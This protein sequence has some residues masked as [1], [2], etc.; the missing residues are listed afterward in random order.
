MEISYESD[1]IHWT[2]KDDEIY[3][4]SFVLQ[5]KNTWYPSNL[6]YCKV[7]PKDMV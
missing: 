4:C 2:M 5:K 1:F 7:D 6:Q 3:D